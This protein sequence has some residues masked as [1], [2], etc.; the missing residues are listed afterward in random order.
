[1]EQFNKP[2]TDQQN[3]ETRTKSIGNIELKQQKSNSPISG[4]HRRH[5]K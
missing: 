1:M 4:Q 3:P 5:R 2:K